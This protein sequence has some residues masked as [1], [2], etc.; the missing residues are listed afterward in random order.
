MVE[1]LS[2]Q[3]AIYGDNYELWLNVQIHLAVRAA[4]G[5]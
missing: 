4:N 5:C 2:N 3:S 1:H